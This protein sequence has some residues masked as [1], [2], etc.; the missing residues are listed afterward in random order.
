MA[1][2][3]HILKL[4]TAIGFVVFGKRLAGADEG[5]NDRTPSQT[6]GPFYPNRKPN[7][8]SDLVHRDAGLARGQL[9]RLA[10]IVSDQTGRRVSG[11]RVEIWQADNSGIYRHPRA[12]GRNQ[13]DAHFQG[14]GVTSADQE[15]QCN[16]LTIVPVPYTGRPPHIHVRISSSGHEELITQLYLKDHPENQRDGFASSYFFP[17]K[18]KLMI[19]PTIGEDW[20][21]A[22]FHFVI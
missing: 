6:P 14:Y 18:D 12:P 10:C 16:F 8:N 22:E 4:F 13:V 9:L 11:A 7:D 15:G 21:S 1:T 20:S 5:T 19:D 17:N 2:R 3:R